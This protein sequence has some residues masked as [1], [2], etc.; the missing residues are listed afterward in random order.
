MEWL[1]VAVSWYLYLLLIGLLFFPLTSMIFRRFSFDMGYPF[2][3][4]I[5]ILL[6]SYLIY[7]LSS[8]KI[9]PFS[10]VSLFFIIGLFSIA[11]FLLI[12]LK[13]FSL[14]QKNL[15]III[16]EEIF[17]LTSFLFW[18]YIRGQEPSIH[19]LEKFMDFGFIN[20][21]LR[22]NHFPPLDMWYSFEKI[23]YYYFGHLTGSI[24]IKLTN[25]LPAVGYNL[26][27]SSLFALGVTQSFSIVANVIK[28]L[29]SRIKI[30]SLTIFGLL[31]AF[32]VNLGG[33]LHTIYIFTE[34]YQIGENIKPPPFWQILSGFNPS[35]YFYPNATRFIPYTIH[36]FPSY[37]YVVADLHAHVFDIP[38]VLL[39]IA[40]LF[41]AILNLPFRYQIRLLISTRKV[42]F[43]SF[44]R[45]IDGS[46]IFFSTILGF[47]VA[48]HYMTN[49]SDGPIY[50][51]LSLIIFLIIYGLST[52]FFV[53]F[54][55]FSLSFLLF[56]YPFS[57]HFSP[58][59][60]GIGVNCPP[61]FLARLERL[62]PL[63]F[64]VDKCQVSPLWML[65][66]IWGF[67]WISFF[68]FLL[69]LK[70][71][72]IKNKSSKKIINFLIVIFSFGNLLIFI[73][74]FFYVKDIYPNHFRANTMFKLGYQAFILMSLASSIV[75]FFLKHQKNRLLSSVYVL[76]L[77]FVAI[78]PLFAI[79]SYYG[80]LNKT[81][82]LD[83]SVFLKKLYA[84]DKEIIDWL[85]KNVQ[86]Q[87]LVL[88]AQ[89]DSYT[90]YQ[91][92]SAH[93]GLPT[94]AGWFVHQWLWRGSP[95]F[96]NKRIP[97]IVSIYQSPDIDLTKKL[98]K[99]YQVTYVII[100]SLERKRYPN[101]NE[102]KFR[103]IGNLV[104]QSKNKLGTIYKV[105][106]TH[107]SS[108]TRN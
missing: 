66:V 19:S 84:E 82:Q 90:D 88:E 57:S 91:R 78:Y 27:L 37:S 45:K 100:S 53:F 97:D 64:E 13:R 49:A 35:S 87:P 9:L 14:T 99:K 38:F 8:L 7:V 81:P 73:P 83:G 18:T 96:V 94:I 31:G 79:P 77:F 106:Q 20:S 3:K 104:F 11:N 23:N 75:F 54:T 32:L 74:E 98:L 34:G 65:F 76:F 63:I 51:L 21:I 29:S 28:V 102:E 95:D 85:N 108:Q 89:G 69:S 61:D 93:T 62:G 92:I 86:G 30:F 105:K 71:V 60:S 33:N 39:T 70:S 12:F 107:L 101:L 80:D 56:S 48:V 46:V 26:I 10:R 103:I 59:I 55:I 40:L 5:G 42:P 52:K 67:F 15:F 16:G 68:L 22:T 50:F 72:E 24:L 2:A 44:V 41:M 1:V 43:S 36:E 17:F 6:T 47:L 58:F 25:V 4:T